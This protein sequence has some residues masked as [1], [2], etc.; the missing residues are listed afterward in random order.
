[1]VDR[2]EMAKRVKYIERGREK[3]EQ[4]EKDEQKE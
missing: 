1:M 4:K 3:G 2:Y